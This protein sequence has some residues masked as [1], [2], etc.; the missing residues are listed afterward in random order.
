[1]TLMEPT[2]AYYTTY[3]RRGPLESTFKCHVVSRP[4]DLGG[5]VPCTLTSP[6]FR[7]LVASL[8]STPLYYL[9]HLLHYYLSTLILN[10]LPCSKLVFGKT[11][12]MPFFLACGVGTKSPFSRPRSVPLQAIPRSISSSRTMEVPNGS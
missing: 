4:P 9:L 8:G 2:T 1:M 7:V 5:K 12:K 10:K 11:L 6:Y 3:Y